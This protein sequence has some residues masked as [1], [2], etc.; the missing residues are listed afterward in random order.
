MITAYNV[1]SVKQLLGGLTNICRR[2]R[3]TMDSYSFVR[4]GKLKLK[5]E[6]K[7]K[8]HKRH[9]QPKLKVEKTE[10]F[11]EADAHGG[12][13]SAKEFD[14][15]RDSIAIQVYVA[16]DKQSVDG[17]EVT[18]SGQDVSNKEFTSACYLSATDEGLL[19]IG[20]PRKYGEAPA[21]EEIFTA[22]QVS[23]T[24]VAFKSG[25]GRYLGVSTKPDALLTATADAVG[26]FEQF[27]PVFQDGRSAMLG[28]NNCFLSVDPTTDDIVFK[29]QQAKANEMIAFR[30]NKPLIHDPLLD[31]PEE[32]REGLEKAEVNYVRKFQSWQD[33]KLRL[34]KEE[35]SNVKRARQSGNLYECLLDRREKM[36]SDRYCK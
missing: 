4:P 33:Q 9:L 30:S 36:K 6:K 32:E 8:H 34:S 12:W 16:T 3:D 15:V 13:W 23:D 10:R 14:E 27:E 2:R 24:K 17:P 29:S 7:K 20:P 1:A 18:H 5:G 31:I 22:M 11:L 35:F 26:V 28:A 19:V 21:P 25:Y